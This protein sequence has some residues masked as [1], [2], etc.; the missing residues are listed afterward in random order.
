[1]RSR[2]QTNWAASK[3]KIEEAMHAFQGGHAQVLDIEA[4]LLIE[5]IAMLD[6]AGWHQSP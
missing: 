6:K 3:T 4:L 5:A 1:M 2:Q